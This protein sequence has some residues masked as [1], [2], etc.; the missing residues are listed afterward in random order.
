MIDVR[1]CMLYER[2]MAYMFNSSSCSWKKTF[3]LDNVL[4]IPQKA[5]KINGEKIASK[6]ICAE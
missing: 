1:R 5:E 4:I 2:I 6:D 3:S